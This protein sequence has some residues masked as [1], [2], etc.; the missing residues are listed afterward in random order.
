MKNNV[1]KTDK[2]IRILIGLVIAVLGII[3][4]SWWGI[5][6]IIPIATAIAGKCVLYY[7]FGVNTYSV[8]EK[9]S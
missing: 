2:I 7:F 9:H 5:L 1:G 3:F 6:A 4:Q 8:N